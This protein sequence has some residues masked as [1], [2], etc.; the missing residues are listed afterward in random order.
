MSAYRRLEERFSRAALIGEASAMLYWDMAAMM[1]AGGRASRAEQLACLGVVGHDILTAAETGDLLAAAGAEESGLDPWQGANLC[2]MRRAYRHATA[3]SPDLVAALAKA[4]SACEAA[5]REARPR[6]DFALVLPHLEA[7]LA[8]VRESAAAKS[9]ALGLSPYEALMDEYEP[10][11]RIAWIDAIFADYAG[12]LPEFLGAV[13]ERQRR[14]IP[15]RAAKGPFPVERQHELGLRLMRAIGFDFAHGRLDVSAHPFCG[16]VPDD[17]RLTTRYD[18]ANFATALMGVVHE[19]GHALYERGLPADWRR[20]PVGQARGMALHESQSLLIEMQA[21]RSAPFLAWL[22]PLLREAFPGN[23][24]AFTAD[25]LRRLYRKVEPGFIR[26][27]AD[28]VTYPAHVILRYRLEQALI[29]G[30]L[31]LADLPAAW[32]EGFS[33]LLGLQVPEDRLGCLQ[34]IHWYDGTFGYFP[35]YSLGAMIAAQLFEAALRAEPGIPE[36]I[37]RGDFAPLLAW[38]RREVHALASSLSTEGIVARA[39]GRPLDPEV[40]KRHLRRRYLEEA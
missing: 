30:D 18:S 20:Q 11:A 31:P 3:L 14:A 21:A 16:G 22:A 1:P 32:N 19:T 33:L 6:S 17:V 37:G 36:A 40:F 8:L 27:D 39:T 34:D 10:G 5:W 38:L 28:E 26:V 9:A 13:L 24:D 2:E 25:N 4:R 29:A 15:A 7:L 35:C 23:D 12:F